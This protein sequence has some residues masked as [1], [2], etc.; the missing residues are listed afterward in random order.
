[1]NRSAANIV[2]V[3]TLSLGACSKSGDDSH[4]TTPAGAGKT[5]TVDTQAVRDPCDWLTKEEVAGILGPLAGEP[6]R[7]LTAESV[8][9]SDD[10]EACAYPVTGRNGVADIALQVDLEGAPELEGGEAMMA[11]VVARELSED[12]HGEAQLPSTR[13]AEWDAVG[14][15]AGER[16]HRAGHLAIRIGDRGSV[17]KEE[18]LDRI[19]NLLRTKI[20]DKP[21][22][23]PG[24]AQFFES[25]S[26]NP[27]DL[28]TRA[29]AEAVLGPLTIAPYRSA[30][31]SALARDDGASCAYY[32]A[33]HRVLVV[34]PRYVGGK[35]DFDMAAG[36]GSLVRSGIG[37]A[38]EGD[39]LDGPWDRATAGPKGDVLFLQG[40]TALTVSYRTSTTDMA[41]AAKLA[42]IAMPRAVKFTELEDRDK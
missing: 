22:A 17:A 21:F 20:A 39:L 12:E 23:D 2:I 25:N 5:A 34:E 8:R 6:Y 26:S 32:S 29:E 3:A 35:E 36:L 13:T 30:K 27:C 40:D 31:S 4:S 14:W 18:S 11:G 33:G 1:M 38:D 42:A 7:V 10:G 16:L 9:A 19:A 28:L 24:P 41:G 37:G 15:Y